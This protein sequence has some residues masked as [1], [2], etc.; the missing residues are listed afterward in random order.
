MSQKKHKSRESRARSKTTLQWLKQHLKPHQC[1]VEISS[2]KGKEPLTKPG[3]KEPRTTVRAQRGAKHPCHYRGA[4][5]TCVN[6][7]GAMPTCTTHKDGVIGPH[8]CGS[9]GRRVAADQDNA[10]RDEAVGPH[11]H[12]ETQRGM[13]WTIWMRRGVGSK[14]HKTT[15]TTTST[16]PVR[17]LLGSANTK[18]TL[19]GTQTVVATR[20]QRTEAAR[21][22][23][24][25]RL[26]RAP[27]RNLN[28]KECHTEGYTEAMHLLWV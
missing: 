11:T 15:R 16:T 18:T 24:N 28:P 1:P 22:G 7:E 21:E 27:S 2:E 10:R 8:A 6:H 26:S 9:M 20:L 3:W 13:W 19:Q 23:K 5:N 17:Q 4:H 25:R 12:T 14:N